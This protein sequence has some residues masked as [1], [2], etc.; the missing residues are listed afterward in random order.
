MTFRRVGGKRYGRGVRHLRSIVYALVL[1]PA[2]WILSGVGFTHDLTGRARESGSVE[3]FT[4]LLLLLLAGAAYGILLFAPISPAGPV[5]F[6][7]VY[8]AVGIW[9]LAAPSSYAGLWP[10]SVAKPGFDL[11]LPGYGLAVLLAVPLICTALS[12]RRWARYEPPQIPLIG[13]LGRPRGAAAVSGTPVGLMH[14]E[15]LQPYG[16]DQADP[17]QVIKLPADPTEVIGSGDA[18]PGILDTTQVVPAPEGDG[19]GTDDRTEVVRLSA[20]EPVVPDDAE[21]PTEAVTDDEAL[22]E[23]VVEDEALTEAVAEDD[24]ESRTELVVVDL[25]D[26]TELVRADEEPRTDLIVIVDAEDGTIVYPPESEPETEAVESPAA[27]DL[28]TVEEPEA[29]PVPDDVIEPEEA[30]QPQDVEAGEAEPVVAQAESEAEEA[31]ASQSRLF[32]PPAPDP[33]SDDQDRTQVIRL[34]SGEV[35]T[36]DLRGRIPPLMPPPD[37]RPTRVIT[38]GATSGPDAGERTQVI[39]VP[40]PSDLETTTPAADEGERTQVI[41]LG[42]G[43]VDPPDERTQVI[44]LPIQSPAR[45]VTA[46]ADPAPAGPSS[47][48]GAER[49]NFAEDPTT[50]LTV[51]KPGEADGPN[52]PSRTMTVTNLERPPDELADDETRPL[53]PAPRHPERD[54]D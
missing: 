49:P 26:R 38:R 54:G 15:I 47:V 22:T 41:R 35:I 12:A 24:A 18:A 34:P 37:E 5:T 33:D 20:D 6:G 42:A 23:A 43:T 13:V 4:G 51:P 28:T 46:D 1:A 10:S 16:R 11:S 44:K 7:L 2:V 40:Q 17:T 21:P 19:P 29:V 53:V 8:L 50:R 3:T 30:A 39:R 52:A 31:E 36:Q 32:E 48:M 9:A 25:D 27:E 45:T 14:T